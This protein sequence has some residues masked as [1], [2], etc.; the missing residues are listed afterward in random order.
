MHF[1]AIFH[2]NNAAAL[3]CLKKTFRLPH[4]LSFTLHFDFLTEVVVVFLA[5]EISLSQAFC[6]LLFRFEM[7]LIINRVTS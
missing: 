1:V 5:W 4:K 2:H 6:N 7:I 3:E